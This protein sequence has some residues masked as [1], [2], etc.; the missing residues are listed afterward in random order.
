M[1][2]KFLFVVLVP[3]FLWIGFWMR[4]FDPETYEIFDRALSDGFDKY[5][6]KG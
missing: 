4:L 1:K 5:Q 2:N 6:K 3:S